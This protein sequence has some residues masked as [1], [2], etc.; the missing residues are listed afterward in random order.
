ML[1]VAAISRS[2]L[3]EAV[4]FGLRFRVSARFRV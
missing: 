4:S 1:E 2:V 3:R